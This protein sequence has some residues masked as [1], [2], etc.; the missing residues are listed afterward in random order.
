MPF[1]HPLQRVDELIVYEG[2]CFLDAISEY[3]KVKDL[4][5]F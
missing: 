1:Q 5:E 3:E 2:M 4:H